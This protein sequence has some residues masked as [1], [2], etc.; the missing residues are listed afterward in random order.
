M[1]VHQLAYWGMYSGTSIKMNTSMN[2]WCN[3]PY[4]KNQID[5]SQKF[6]MIK[7]K[8]NE[9]SR[10][11]NCIYTKDLKRQTNKNENPVGGDQSEGGGKV[12]CRRHQTLF[13]FVF[14]AVTFCIL[15]LL[16]LNLLNIFAKTHQT[17]YLKLG[18]LLY[19]NNT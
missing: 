7:K 8:W 16:L 4:K 15:M 14:S 12:W 6:Y 9:K 17:I 1:N 13:V 10:L 5:G 11:S 19:A 2:Y 18:L 3:T